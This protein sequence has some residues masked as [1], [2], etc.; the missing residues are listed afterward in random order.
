M[1]WTPDDPDDYWGIDAKLLEQVQAIAPIIAISAT[2]RADENTER[3]A[4]L[5]AALGADPGTD[6]LKSAR[7]A[8]DEASAAFDQQMTASFDLVASFYW[9]NDSA[10][11]VANPKDWAHLNMYFEHGMDI[12]E[13]DAEPGTFWEQLSPEQVLKYQSDLFFS[14]SRVDAFTLDQLKEHT[15]FSQH[16]AIKAGQLFPWNQDFIQSYQGMTEAMDAIR[17]AFEGSTKV[18]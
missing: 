7:E 1:S 14:S 4:E 17:S 12:I 3:F 16:P 10:V 18:I 6:E 9:V 8:Y 11:Y 2:G 15:A 13:P 5:A